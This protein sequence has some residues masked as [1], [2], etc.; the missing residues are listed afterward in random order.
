MTKRA[1][2]RATRPLRDE[3]VVL[4]TEHAITIADLAS[5]IDVHP[6]RLSHVVRGVAPI[7]VT[8]EVA[9]RMTDVFGLRPDY[10]YEV[11]KCHL[12]ERITEDPDLI[13]RLYDRYVGDCD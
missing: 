13:D 3:L 1:C 8:A 12:F 9:A 2:T 7:H 10:F 4:L 5:M 6:T 11:R